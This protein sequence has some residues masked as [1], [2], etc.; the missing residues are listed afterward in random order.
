MRNSLD[1]G[2]R[3]GARLRLALP[4][5]NMRG[6]VG[7]RLGS[8]T[9]SSLEFQDYRDYQAGDDIRRLDWAAYARSDRLTVRLYRDEIQPRLDILSDLSDS[10]LTPTDAK[11]KAALHVAGAF[12]EASFRSGCSVSW[13]GFGGG[14]R[15]L[16]PQASSFPGCALPDW[17]GALSLEEELSSSIPRL[18]WRGV[19][20]V[21][22]DFLWES[23]PDGVLRRLCEGASRV[24]LAAVLTEEEL[25][26]PRYGAATLLDSEGAERLELIVGDAE[27]ASYLKR[28][29]AHIALWEDAAMSCGSV[30]CLLRARPGGQIDLTPLLEAGALEFSG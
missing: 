2:R 29:E 18:A 24:M 20:V 17:G 15:E 10:M 30:F 9:G 8:S 14:W 21:I 12:A 28:L 26:P 3:A 27:R 7:E 4:R 13:R 11:A 19:R 23:P 16:F 22:S 1:D 6:G 25:E 5:H